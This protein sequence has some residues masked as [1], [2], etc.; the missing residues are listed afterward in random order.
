MGLLLTSR[1]DP[2]EL[3]LF[4]ASL[5]IY[6][7]SGNLTR[8]LETVTDQRLTTTGQARCYKDAFTSSN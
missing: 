3:T 5:I 4:W 8:R 1:I 2:D 7:N 6:E